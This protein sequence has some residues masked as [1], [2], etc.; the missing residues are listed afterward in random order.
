MIPQ[1]EIIGNPALRGQSTDIS[2][3]EIFSA[4]R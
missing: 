3:V 1:R 2:R 4:N